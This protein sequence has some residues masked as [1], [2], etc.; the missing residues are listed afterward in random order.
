MPS[1]ANGGATCEV[2][3]ENMSFV[4][5]PKAECLYDAFGEFNTLADFTSCQKLRE[6]C[7]SESACVG[8]GHNREEYC[9]CLNANTLSG[10]QCKYTF[11]IHTRRCDP[12]S[13]N[14]TNC[15]KPTKKNPFPN[16]SHLP[17]SPQ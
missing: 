9:T 3:E 2:N 8:G 13:D 16:C 1:F 15:P 4:A 6:H 14:G 17:A 5:D 11:D 12:K 7:L 10:S